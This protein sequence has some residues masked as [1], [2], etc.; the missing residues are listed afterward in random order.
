MHLPGMTA[1]SL[2][3]LP[4]LGGAGGVGGV[5]GDGFCCCSIV[6]MPGGVAGGDGGD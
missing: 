6:Q 2:T 4:V 3:V 5:E 1:R